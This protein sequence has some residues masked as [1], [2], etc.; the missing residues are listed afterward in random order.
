MTWMVELPSGTVSLLFSDIEGS[1]V[2]L[3]RLGAA[4]ADALD[5]QRRVLRRPGRPTAARSWAPRATASSWCSRPR[6]RRWRRRRRRSGSSRRIAWPAGERVRVRMGIHTGSPVVARRWVRG[7]G[8]A[9]RGPDRRGRARWSGGAVGRDRGRW[10]RTACPPACVC[11]DL[12]AHRLKDIAAPEQLF[13][14][15]IDGLPADF[16]PLKTLGAASSL[17]VPATPLVGRDGEVAELAALLGQPDVRLV[18]LTGPGGSGK[19]RLAIGLA[20]RLVAIFPDGVY[21]V[22][23]AAVTTAQV[24]WT[25]IG[26]ALDVPPE[27]RIPPALLRRIWRTAARCSCSTTSSSSPGADSVVV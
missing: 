9:P 10:C 7:D 15:A 11:C 19:T 14:L 13:Q 26:E 5:G 20:Q 16:P 21:F 6:R 27:R 17:P 2:L 12:G 1:T 25:A 3:S 23:L 18:T 22:P 4:Y 24:M 8:R